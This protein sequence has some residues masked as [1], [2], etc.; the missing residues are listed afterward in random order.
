MGYRILFSDKAD[1]QF[2]KLDNHAKRQI[3]KYIDIN[4]DN[5]LNPRL[6]GKALGGDLKNLWRYRVGDYRIICRIED[7]ICEILV[8]KVG[9]RKDVYE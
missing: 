3:E 7:N 9:H 1:K 8:V 2:E 6:H 4:L 5:S